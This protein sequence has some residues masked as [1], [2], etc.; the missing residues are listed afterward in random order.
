M[1]CHFC[2]HHFTCMPGFQ[3]H[4]F[5]GLF[6]VANMT[7]SLAYPAPRRW[8]MSWSCAITTRLYALVWLNRKIFDIH[9]SVFLLIFLKSPFLFEQLNSNIVFLMLP[10]SQSAQSFR[11]SAST[12]NCY[13][14]VLI[15]LQSFCMSIEFNIGN[16]YILKYLN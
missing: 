12:G 8:Y 4:W 16:F 14:C 13:W 1:L 2:P 7:M 11:L 5:T 10:S 6:D 15:S 3:I 9:L